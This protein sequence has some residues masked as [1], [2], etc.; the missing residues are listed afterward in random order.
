M[1]VSVVSNTVG[2]SNHTLGLV[3]ASTMVISVWGTMQHLLLMSLP[4]Q[5]Q[6]IYMQ[7]AFQANGLQQKLHWDLCT[8]C[9]QVVL[10]TCL[11]NRSLLLMLISTADASVVCSWKG[12]TCG[13]HVGRLTSHALHLA[14]L[15]A[16]YL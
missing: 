9:P 5:Q 14:N 10:C 12:H 8:R 7:L 16:W 4:V 15:A 2:T 6:T 1:I 3:C 13:V 11:Q